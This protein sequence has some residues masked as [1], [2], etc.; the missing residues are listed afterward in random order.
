MSINFNFLDPLDNF[1][2]SNHTY[3]TSLTINLKRGKKEWLY[4]S[5]KKM[6]NKLRNG[7]V[8]APHDGHEGLLLGSVDDFINYYSENRVF[9][10]VNNSG[11]REKDFNSIN[12]KVDLCIGCSFTF[13]VGVNDKDTWVRKLERKLDLPL[14]NLGIGGSGVML[15]FRTLCHFLSIFDVRNVFLFSPLSHYRYEWNTADDSTTEVWSP[16]EI[17]MFPYELGIVASNKSNH[18]LIYYAFNKAIEQVCYKNNVNLVALY[19]I[20]TPFDEPPNVKKMMIWDY[21][22]RDLGHPGPGWQEWIANLMYKKL[23]G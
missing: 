14:V 20:P 4:P 15:H 10:Q 17:E 6:W 9:Y 22:A 18:S 21:Y 5:E 7:E 3:L 16:T 8:K 23:V 11:F 13:G 19:E 2:Y 12:G 1:Y